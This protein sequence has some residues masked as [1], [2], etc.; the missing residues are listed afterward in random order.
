VRRAI[1]ERVSKAQQEADRAALL[2]TES[3]MEARRLRRALDVLPEGVVVCDDSGQVVYRNRAAQALVDARDADVLA[4]RAVEEVLAVARLGVPEERTVELFGPPPRTL[5]IEATP[6][7]AGTVA[8]IRDVTAQRQLDTVRR[9]FVSNVSH[10]LRTPVGALSVLAETLEDETDLAVVRRLA[11]RIS[12]EVARAEQ[13]IVDLLDLSRI[14]SEGGSAGEPV[15]MGDV[16]VAAVERAAEKATEMNVAIDSPDV[17]ADIAVRGRHGQLVSAVGNLLDNAVAY[18]E[19]G[20]QVF[21]NIRADGEW[22]DVIVRD[23]GIGIPGKDLERIFERFYRV[24]RARSRET[25][26]TGLG[27]SIVRHVATN[28]GGAVTVAS[29]EGEGSTFIIRLPRLR[30]R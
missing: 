30:E 6:I 2:A 11:G 9:D 27:L 8:V 22:V 29:R 4:A 26:G 17:P 25:G 14:E 28:H 13:M 1:Q 21:V 7:T 12:S 23:E 3:G 10:E 15:A 16:V 20:G 18:S 24:D 5:T 19:R